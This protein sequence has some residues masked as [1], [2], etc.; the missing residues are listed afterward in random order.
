GDERARRLEHRIAGADANPYLVLAAVLAGAHY[1]ISQKIDPGEASLG[2]NMSGETDESIPLEWEQAISRL[3][4]S[5]FA[6]AY[7]EREYIDTYCAL[8]RDELKRFNDYVSAHE[9]RLYL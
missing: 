1:G 9:F 3:H 6:E 8:R 4:E 2:V 7:F 5:S